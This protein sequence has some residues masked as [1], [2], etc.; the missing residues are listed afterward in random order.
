M[1]RTSSF[2]GD[3][4]KHLFPFRRSLKDEFY[5]RLLRETSHSLVL[6]SRPVGLSSG[7]HS[8]VNSLLK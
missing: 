3:V 2:L 7:T 1:S 4:Y 5:R 8:Q 6:S